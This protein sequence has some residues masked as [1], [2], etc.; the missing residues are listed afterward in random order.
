[1]NWEAFDWLKDQEADF[2]VCSRASHLVR[3]ASR[4][5]AELDARGVEARKP[6]RVR[7]R[8]PL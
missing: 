5:V 8:K 7:M 6:R 1:M 3:K 4:I 2:A